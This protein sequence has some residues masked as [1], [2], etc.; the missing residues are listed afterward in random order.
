MFKFPLD[1]W[2][3]A[4]RSMPDRLASVDP[5]FQSRD[6]TSHHTIPANRGRRVSSRVPGPSPRGNKKE[7]E[8]F[9]HIMCVPPSRRVG[10]A[11]P[12]SKV[13]PSSARQGKQARHPAARSTEAWKSQD[14]R[15]TVP[16]RLHVP[17]RHNCA[18][19][20]PG[21]LGPSHGPGT[22]LLEQT[23]DTWCSYWLERRFGRACEPQTFAGKPCYGCFHGPCQRHQAQRP[24][25][26]LGNERPIQ[27]Q[28][29]RGCLR[30]SVWRMCLAVAA[31]PSTREPGDPGS[32]PL[33]VQG[34]GSSVLGTALAWVV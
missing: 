28:G 9:S 31:E 21:E 16:S 23:A 17:R 26:L 13:S 29:E 8:K 33:H 3:A 6:K 1:H 19:A 32:I 25:A 12:A 4:A 22:V 14:I 30:C 34:C 10:E 15:E 27:S 24:E 20:Q 2:P 11:G 18:F 7:F 5:R